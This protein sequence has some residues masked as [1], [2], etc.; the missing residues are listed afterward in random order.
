MA[1][2]SRK[3]LGLIVFEWHTFKISVDICNRI[4]S[5]HLQ[6]TK[7]LLAVFYE[8]GLHLLR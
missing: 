3:I 4:K 7:A 8:L 5:N 1:Y 6:I 2:E